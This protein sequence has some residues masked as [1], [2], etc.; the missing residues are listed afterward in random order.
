VIRAG[1]GEPLVLL[2]GIGCAEGIW[3]SVVPLVAPFHDTIAMTATG[4]RGGPAAVTRPARVEHLVD[5]LERRLDALRVSTAHL[6]GN[7]M[8][9]WMALELARRGRARTVC[10]LSPAG[11]W[12]AGS[13][14]HRR[15]RDKLRRAERD[16]RRARPLMPLL[17]RS[18]AMR[19]FALR[20]SAVH[21]ERVSRGE[22]IALGDDLVGCAVLQ[23]LLD[24]PEQLQPLDPL[25][26]PVTIAWSRGDRVLPL[27][28]NGE[29][30]QQLFPAARFVALDD[31]GHVPMF[32]DPALVAETILEAARTRAPV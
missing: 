29:R 23:E 17:L 5:N 20:T 32:D 3:N 26:C 11:T 24:S 1:S 10:A 31:V 7:S 30:A 16:T 25:A 15:S 27:A 13:E 6:A 4:H 8:G 28:I 14:S 12:E 19:R 9:G 21:G 2:H 22:L 18:A